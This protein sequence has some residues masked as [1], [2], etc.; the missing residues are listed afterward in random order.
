MLLEQKLINKNKN[1]NP[2]DIS[3]KLIKGYYGG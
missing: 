1:I 3:K 2:H